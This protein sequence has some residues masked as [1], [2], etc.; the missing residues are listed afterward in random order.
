[1]WVAASSWKRQANR[2]LIAWLFSLNSNKHTFRLSS[3]ARSTRLDSTRTTELLNSS[4]AASHGCWLLRSIVVLFPVIAPSCDALSIIITLHRPCSFAT[5]SPAELWICDKPSFPE[6]SLDCG[7]IQPSHANS[8]TNNCTLQ[9]LRN[10][11]LLADYFF[12]SHPLSWRSVTLHSKQLVFDGGG[13]NQFSSVEQRETN[14]LA[15]QGGG[16]QCVHSDVHGQEQRITK[17]EVNAKET[18]SSTSGTRNSTT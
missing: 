2:K 12:T 4:L 10:S 8:L 11:F 3:F 17:T 18:H 13:E 15:S 6:C 5:L 14:Q 9:L 7:P 1:M 16:G